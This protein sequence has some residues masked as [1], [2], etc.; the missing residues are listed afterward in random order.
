M[1]RNL[2]TQ[3]DRQLKRRLHGHYCLFHVLQY[4]PSVYSEFSHVAA[5]VLV[6]V[7]TFC[8]F[9]KLPCVLLMKH[10]LTPGFDD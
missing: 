6:S 4:Y 7:S 10:T 1:E 5:F 2:W 9:S 8:A 3:S